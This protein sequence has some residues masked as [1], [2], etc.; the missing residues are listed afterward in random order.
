M[1]RCIGQ[2][3][4]GDVAVVRS[5]RVDVNDYAET[6]S[7]T[8]LVR[9]TEQSLNKNARAANELRERTRIAGLFGLPEELLP[10]RMVM[11]ICRRGCFVFLIHLA[12]EMESKCAS[13]VSNG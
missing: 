3:V 4:F 9:M 13:P 6:F 11:Q 12:L 5:S 2:V 1:S 10:E 8:E 7:R